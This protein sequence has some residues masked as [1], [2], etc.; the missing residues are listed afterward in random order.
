MQYFLICEENMWQKKGAA[1]IMKC[2]IS[3]PQ[4]VAEV[5][6]L[7]E[8]EASQTLRK[9]LAVHFFERNML[10]FGQ[11]RQWSGLSV[12]EFMDLLREQKV[13]FHY[14]VYELEE[15]FQVTGEDTRQVR[16]ECG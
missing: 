6:G 12:W 11:A 10:S 14:D 15:D 3:L 13:P 1:L 2:E 16:A 9:E 8:S 7:T 4:S 5:L